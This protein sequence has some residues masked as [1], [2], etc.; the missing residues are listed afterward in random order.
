MLYTL[1]LDTFLGLYIHFL[2]FLSLIVFKHSFGYENLSNRSR[3]ETCPFITAACK[4]DHFST[5]RTLINLGNF[6]SNMSTISL[7]PLYAAMY[8]G[9][10]LVTECILPSAPF[11][12]SDQ[13]VMLLFEMCKN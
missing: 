11:Y 10:Y 3:V 5:V 9:E 12:K 13:I 7:R 8:K 2:P 4:G 1:Y 6:F